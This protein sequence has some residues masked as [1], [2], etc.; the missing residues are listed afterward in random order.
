ML[1][2]TTVALRGTWRGK[3]R[4]LSDGGS[5][6]AG[7]LVAR[8]TREGV[9][10]YYKYFG[11]DRRKRLLAIGPYDPQGVRGY[12]LVKAR[13]RAAE[14][15]ALFRSGAKDLHQHFAR[16]EATA[17]RNRQ[18]EETAR[19]LAQ[20]EAERGTLREL[21]A[22]YVTHLRSLGKSSARD[23]ENLFKNHVLKNGDLVSRKASSLSVDDFVD[24]LGK[25]VA[26]RKGRTAGKVRSYLRAA[27]ALALASKTDPA[28]PSVLKTFGISANPMASIDALSQFNRTRHR[29]L[30]AIEL[31]GVLKRLED[32]PPSVQRDALEL[33]L[34]LGGQR[35]T[36]LLRA[37]PADVDLEALT[38]QLYDPKGARTEPRL[39]V[40]PLTAKAAAVVARR[41]EAFKD[42][43]EAPLF[44]TDGVVAM[45]AETLWALVDELSGDM[46]K[47]RE[48]RDAFQL[49]DLR[50]TAE[51]MLASLGT[52]PHIRG[53]V[54][55][56]GLGGVQARHY[57]RHD[58]L[59]EKRAVLEVWDAHLETLRL[60]ADRLQ[61]TMLTQAAA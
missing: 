8:L 48:A 6:G 18:E 35:P 31:G 50:R 16:A 33:T 24:V 26:A 12:S 9:G 58:Y 21:L 45:R 57:D 4:W 13:D 15:S 37:T 41:L 54:Q 29:H 46:V 19:R 60:A 5:R 61:S 17:E 38:I 14:L 36:Q 22:L 30:S 43:P 2:I 53:Q 47:A 44:T 7:R 40:L 25:V 51:T 1:K 59:S 56:H 39:H 49:R 52:P 11:P 27:Y 28:A 20:E 42:L 3:D 10:F 32:L 55:S 23:V 34:R